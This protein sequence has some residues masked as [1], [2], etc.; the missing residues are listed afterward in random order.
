MGHRHRGS[1]G[2]TGKAPASEVLAHASEVYS[3]IG[4][5]PEA[6]EA[7]LLQAYPERPNPIFEALNGRLSIRQLRV[8]VEH[9]PRGPVDREVNGP[10]GDI[11]YLLHDIANSLR[12]LNTTYSNVHRPKG[13]PQRKPTFLPGPDDKKQDA[14]PRS[15]QQIQAEQDHLLAVLARDRG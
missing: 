13:A 11:E 10:W 4:Q 3:L 15:E 1:P 14:D 12:L 2:G 5:A 8:M 6:Y 9:L 7:A